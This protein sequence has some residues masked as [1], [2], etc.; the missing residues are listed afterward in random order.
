MSVSGANKDKL[1][2]SDAQEPKITKRKN[3]GSKLGSQQHV[4]ESFK[5]ENSVFEE[6]MQ[7]PSKI[8]DKDGEH[9]IQL[10][11]ATYS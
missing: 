8:Q 4:K 5:E 7:T 3:F 6:R 2:A 1:P 11:K 10:D 9:D